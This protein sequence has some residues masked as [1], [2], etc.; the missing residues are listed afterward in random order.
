MLPSK[1][2]GMYTSKADKILAQ[3]AWL[4]SQTEVT[5]HRIDLQEIL[6]RL[7]AHHLELLD[8]S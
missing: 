1:T 6:K 8:I 5:Q 4:N 3:S 2:A 7:F